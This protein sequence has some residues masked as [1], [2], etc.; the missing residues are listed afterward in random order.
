MKEWITGRNPVYEVLRAGKRQVFKLMVAGAA[1][2]KGRIADIIQLA[3]Q[4]RIKVEKVQRQQLDAITAGEANRTESHQGVAIQVSGYQYAD[5]ADIWEL[6]EKR[7]EPMFILLLDMIQNPQNLGTLLRTAE[8][9]G[10]HGVVMPLA[11]A[12]GITPAVVHASV[13]ASEHLHIVQANLAQVVEDLK[14][15][16]VWVVGL[17]GGEG[18]TLASQ[19]RLDGALALVVGNEGEGIRPLVARKC[20]VMM[21]LPMRGKVESLNAAVAGSVALYLAYNTRLK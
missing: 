5:L 10:V 15:K 14:K 9:V 6:A 1:E 12:A 13:G 20:D 21:R 11:R 16:D 8:V 4:K 18:S 17:E 2:E 3:N 7:A 19:V